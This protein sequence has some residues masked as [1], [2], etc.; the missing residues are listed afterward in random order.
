MSDKNFWK[1]IQFVLYYIFF[2][3]SYDT[4]GFEF[5]NLV[6]GLLPGFSTQY[7]YEEVRI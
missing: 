1:K 4:G 5:T 7:D 2:C 6:D 3:C